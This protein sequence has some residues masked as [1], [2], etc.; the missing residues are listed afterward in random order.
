M[1]HLAQLVGKQYAFDKGPEFENETARLQ[2]E[3]LYLEQQVEVIIW[4][5]MQGESEEAQTQ[6][7]H[8]ASNLLEHDFT[9]TKPLGKLIA[10]ITELA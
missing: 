6:P 5:A 1:H 7:S 9:A 2:T 4:L 8:V 10:P 3:N